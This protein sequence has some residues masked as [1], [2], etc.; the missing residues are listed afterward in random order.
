MKTTIRI[1]KLELNNLFYSPLAWLVLVGFSIFTAYEIIPDLT[2]MAKILGLY[3]TESGGITRRLFTHEKMGYLGHTRTLL[4]VLIPLISMGVI[5]REASSGSIKLLYS[6][7]IKLGSIVMGK[8]LGVMVFVSMLM[9]IS[10]LAIFIGNFTVE[11]L[12]FGSLISVF[13]HLYLFAALIAAIGVF[14]STFSAYP[15]VD[16]VATI[17]LVYGLDLLYGLVDEVPVV[18]TIMYWIAPSQQMGYA[19]KGLVTSQSLLYF[20]VLIIVFVCWAYFRMVLKRQTSAAK[21]M[22]RAKMTGLLVFAMGVIYITTIPTLL[23]YKDMSATQKNVLSPVSKEALVDLKDQPIKITTYV[24]LFH[25]DTRG[26]MPEDHVTSK[27]FF[28]KYYLE[29]PQIE[30]DFVYFYKPSQLEG[31]QRKSLPGDPISLDET[32]KYMSNLLKMDINDIRHI[33]E[34]GLSDD[35]VKNYANFH[36]RILES[37]GKKSI[38]KYKFNDLKAWP[39][40]A[41]ITAAFKRLVGN[42]YKIACVEGHRE[43][44]MDVNEKLASTRTAYRPKI[45]YPEN[46]DLAISS[47]DQRRSLINNGFEVVSLNLSQEVPSDVDVLLIA[48]PKSEFSEQELANLKKYNDKGGHLIITSGRDNEKIM[49]PI[50]ADFGVEYL[51]GILVNDNPEYPADYNLAESHG[52]FKES[53]RLNIPVGLGKATALK[54]D[55]NKGFKSFVLLSSKG[56]ETWMDAT[57][58]NKFG[59]ITYNEAE[60]DQKASLPIAVQLER[61][62]NNKSQKVLIASDADFLSNG[63]RE[64]GNGSFMPYLSKWMT[65]GDYPLDIP[66]VEGKDNRVSI[67]WENIIWLSLLMYFLVP[68]LFAFFGG[69]MLMKRMKN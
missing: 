60:G 21:W 37:K 41:Q 51:P 34:L 5:S 16:A 62:V 6:S 67:A 15:I 39:A 25:G 11:H 3:H 28:H 48:E 63:S 61:T 43:R 57:G 46:Y 53:L 47:A 45:N 33:D 52:E 1:A 56:K 9:S 30:M 65:N 50:V 36:F 10:L 8:Y 4:M 29:Y 42:S 14:I 68:G 20:V 64:V 17:A 35:I 31:Y 13:I 27:D 66:V 18:S 26:L 69:R 55:E 2:H 7:P 54:L 40:Q 38:L 32:I 24:N 23:W 22:T 44:G 19:F 12:D 49:N 58:P 59:E